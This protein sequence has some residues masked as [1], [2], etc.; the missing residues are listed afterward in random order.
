MADPRLLY[1]NESS[2]KF[3]GFE[4]RNSPFAVL[5]IPMDITS[6]FR[7]GSRFAPRKIREMSQFIEFYSLRTG[8][9]VGE[10]GFEDLGD[11][12]LHPS[13]VEQNV[14]RIRDVV[15]Y[16]SEKGKIVVSMGGEHTI[17]VGTV[18]GTKADCVV[19]FDAHLDLRDEYMGYKFDH[20]CVMHR[21]AER[22]VRIMEVGNRAVSREEVEYAKEFGV[23]F[24]TSH[25]VN[26]I[27]T[28]EVAMKV[29]NFL[30]PCNRI[31]ITFDVDSVD[32]AYAPGVA[33]PEPEGLTPTVVLDVINLIADSRVVGFD[34]VEISPPYDPSDIT[35][36]L[37]AKL[38]ME[39]TSIV[40][41]SLKKGKGEVR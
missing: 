33:T 15:S 8:V 31:Y 24:I 38:I 27:G 13:D 7:P 5:G 18:L 25:E 20:A 21:L 41:S 36:V 30:R 4:K 17:T 28:R 14:E 40:S 19:S 23:P 1:L 2:L 9:D 26:L 16:A 35:S 39:T 34:V 10:V 37:G 32:P 22:G 6:S 29:K 3:G 12:V 11:V